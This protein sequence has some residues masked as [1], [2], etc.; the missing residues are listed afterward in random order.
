VHR[1]TTYEY[2]YNASVDSEGRI[3]VFYWPGWELRID[4][5]LRPEILRLGPDGLISVNFPAGS[6]HA[7]LRYGLSREGRIARI[8]SSSAAVIWILILAVG[9]FENG[10]LGRKE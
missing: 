6:H 3:A 5:K 1:G 10:K 8:F 4:G 7:E 2:S 9:W